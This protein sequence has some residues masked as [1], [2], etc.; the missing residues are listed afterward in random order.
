MLLKTLVVGE[1]AANCYILADQDTREALVIDPGAEGPRIAAVLLDLKVKPVLLMS[2]HSHFDHT[3]GAT[4]LRNAYTPPP[5]YAIHRSDESTLSRGQSIR[6]AFLNFED[7]PKPE[8]LLRE[9]DTIEVGRVKLSVLDTPGHTPG[10]IS[11]YI[12]G[13]AHGQGALV[14]TGDTLFQMSIGR[15]DF[16][17][18]N[19]EQELA[20]IRAKLFTLPDA[21]R[22]YPGHGPTTTIGQEKQLNP[23]LKPQSH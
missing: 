7:P 18:G 22:A 23:F 20:S 19:R 12:P 1:L 13:D 9:G 11:L 21:T 4:K 5:P 10:S 8:R 6:Q 2:T 15:T 14:F 17:G 3:G 16:P